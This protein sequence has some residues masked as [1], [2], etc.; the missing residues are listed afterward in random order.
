MDKNFSYIVSGTGL[1]IVIDNKPYVV[2][3][4][5]L[6]YSLILDC[7][8]SKQ[9]SQ[10]PDL[11]NVTKVITNFVQP[12]INTPTD[13]EVD[14]ESETI[15]YKGE[16]VH[17]AVVYYIFEM[18]KKGFPIDSLL[19]FL[20]NL[21]EN[22]SK[23]TIDELYSFLD[24]GKMPI[25]EDGCFI[26][27]KRVNNNYTSI[28]DNKTDNSIGKTVE[29]P[30]H[31][32]D[33]RSDNTCSHGLHICSFD[34]L[35]YYSGDKVIVVKVHPADVVSVPTDYKNTKARVCKYVV[36]GELNEHDASVE[37]HT[38]NTPVAATDEVVVEAKEPNVVQTTMVQL[39]QPSEWYKYGY[40]YGYQE[41]KDKEDIKPDATLDDD[42]SGKLTQ[43]DIDDVNAGYTEGY[44]HG[45]G[46]KG[47]KYPKTDYPLD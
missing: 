17:N 24:Y 30:R 9:Y 12:S 35:Q 38:F 44:K 33:D 40:T 21:Y 43:L 10:I 14:T 15:K 29:M 34:Y 19:K 7:I 31:K 45:R 46:H 11:V 2:N 20:T 37:K 5:H 13:F 42:E 26:A 25:T 41:G 8:K 28:Y 47:R 36:I 18:I 22:P 6:N 4:T 23:K 1:S 27:Y 3:N 32:V 16:V 39:M